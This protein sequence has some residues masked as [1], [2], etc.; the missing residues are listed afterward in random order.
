MLEFGYVR[1]YR[2]LLNWEWYTD[3]HTK[4]VFLHLILTANYEA[5]QWRGITIERG[6]RIYSSQKLAD[7]LHMSRQVIRTAVNHLIST[8]EI[9]NQSTPQFSIITIK[10]YD[11]YQ[12]ATNDLTNEQ[13][14]TNQPS[15][16]EQPQCK[17]A[18]ESKKAIR[19]IYSEYRDAFLKCCPSLPK[20][21]ESENWSDGRKKRIRDKKMTAEEMSP[22]FERI[23]KSDF[24]SGR[25]GKWSGCSFDWIL[26]PENWKKIIEGNY[27]N[28][29]P[30]SQKSKG[31]FS[32]FSN[33]DIEAWERGDYDRK[34][35]T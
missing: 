32:S 16:N 25:N 8:G 26:K 33:E 11:S 9:T 29:E 35:N 30:S 2:S 7:E 22:V 5:K 10:N 19:V 31:H 13:P 15:T 12:Q 24:L 1:L 34:E 17:K 21:E 14:T 6:Q 28:R 20:P 27:D 18:K 4:T 3:E 23:E